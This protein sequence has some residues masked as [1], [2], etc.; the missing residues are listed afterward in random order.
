VK[1]ATE[2]TVLPWSW[3]IDRIT[4]FNTG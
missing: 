4:R 2:Q 1:K 3:H